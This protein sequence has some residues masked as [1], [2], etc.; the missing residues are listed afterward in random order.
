MLVAIY[1]TQLYGRRWISAYS[2]RRSAAW[3]KSAGFWV[4]NGR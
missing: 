2:H 3:F 4:T 1:T